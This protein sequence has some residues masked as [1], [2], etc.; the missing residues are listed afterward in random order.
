MSLKV[1]LSLVAVDNDTGK[2]FADFTHN[3]HDMSQSAFVQLEE[4]L[5]KLQG[6]LLTV[7]KQLA[8]Q[9]TASPTKN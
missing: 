1:T 5:H 7:G 3:F 4:M 2:E 6:D 8:A 9:S